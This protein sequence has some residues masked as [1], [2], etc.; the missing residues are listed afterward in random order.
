MPSPNKILPRPTAIKNDVID[1]L[2]FDACSV[3]SDMDQGM[4]KNSLQLR[5]G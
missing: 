5:Q 3:I 1:T 2:Y 4:S